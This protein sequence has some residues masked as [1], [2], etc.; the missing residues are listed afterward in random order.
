MANFNLISRQSSLG[1]PAEAPFVPYPFEELRSLGTAKKPSIADD[2]EKPSKDTGLRQVMAYGNEMSVEDQNY[3]DNVNKNIESRKEELATKIMNTPTQLGLEG[4]IKKFV[5]GVQDEKQYGKYAE[6]VRNN[7]Q[8]DLLRAE[9]KKDDFSN[10]STWRYNNTNLKKLGYATARQDNPDEVPELNFEDDIAAIPDHLDRLEYIDKKLKDIA[11][12]DKTGV[13]QLLSGA[14]INILPIE[15]NDYMVEVQSKGI[16]N[17][18]L[19]NIFNTIFDSK[20]FS[21]DITQQLD[22]EQTLADIQGK[23]FNRTERA[24][25]IKQNLLNYTISK[26]GGYTSTRKVSAEKGTSYNFSSGGASNKN[27][28]FVY[29]T[30]KPS[31]D[32]NWIAEYP[33]L[34]P[35]LIETLK[36]VTSD[37]VERVRI[38]RISTEK[39]N[40]PFSITFDASGN[41][42]KATLIQ[43]QRKKGGEWELLV[44][45]S[46]KDK[47]TGKM[48]PEFKAIPNKYAWPDIKAQTGEKDDPGMTLERFLKEAGIEKEKQPEGK[49]TIPTINTQAEYEKLPSG[50][51]YRNSAGEEGTKK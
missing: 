1:P 50:T 36:T 30:G 12:T 33:E 6:I 13:D 49:G 47:E 48:K 11:K 7:K 5:S 44:I 14:G 2:K 23:E 38:Q 43:W 22:E 29:S 35:P 19:T 41:R 24:T 8:M 40:E 10:I 21:V 34:N 4:E 9:E 51:K 45:H 27:W 42:K 3:L 46:I 39:E 37:V 25:E 28:N 15:G 26:K 18:K 17:P 31:P 32:F 20:Q 16:S